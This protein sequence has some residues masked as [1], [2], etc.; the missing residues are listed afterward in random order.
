MPD[1]ISAG[2]RIYYEIDGDGPAVVI[3]HGFL[4]SPTAWRDAGYVEALSGRYQ[5]ILIE[6]RGHGRSDKPSDPSVY[7]YEQMAG[8]VLAVLDAC[9][10]ERTHFW[11]YSMGGCIGYRLG[12]IAPGRFQ[13]LVL[14]GAQPYPVAEDDLAEVLMWER[15]LRQ[16]MGAFIDGM[17]RREGPLPPAVR[18]RWLAL[19]GRALAALVE[20]QVAGDRTGIPEPFD[21]LSMPCLLYAGTADPFARDL[22][23]AAAALPHAT[24]VLFG[25]CDHEGAFDNT[26]IIPIVSAFLERAGD[27]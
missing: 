8:D 6:A 24:A 15:D 7:S 27:P 18:T 17:E 22:P 20:G 21:D 16:G 3:Q 23:R 25:G 19:D 12:R 10:I 9:G 2:V 26:A 4:G 11:G 1:T 14:G 13:S 5:V